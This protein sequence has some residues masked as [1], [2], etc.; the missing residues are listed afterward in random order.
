MTLVVTHF[1]RILCRILGSFF[2]DCMPDDDRFSENVAGISAELEMGGLIH[3]L[4]GEAKGYGPEETRCQLH[5]VQLQVQF[6]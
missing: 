1:H 5:S 3:P 4:V 6:H 2:E